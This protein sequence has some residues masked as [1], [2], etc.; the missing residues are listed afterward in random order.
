M[1]KIHRLARIAAFLAKLIV[2]KGVA[3]FIK[4]FKPSLRNVWIISERG[5]DA[6][7]NGYFFYRY[8]VEKHP[9]QKLWYIISSSSPDFAR[10][11]K[12]GKW[13]EYESFRHYVFY[14][15]AK[16]RISSSLWGGDLPKMSYF[17]QL[18][19]FMGHRKK[20]VFLKHGIIKD[21]L[22]QHCYGEGFPD[23]YV[24][25][26][27]P[28]FEYV[29]SNFGYP[30]GIVRYL[31]LARFD[32]LHGKRTKRQVLIMPTFRKWLPS[33][34]REEISGSEYVI[35]WNRAINDPRL[36]DLLEKKEI[37]LIFYP[38]HVMQKN[39]DLFKSVSKRIHIA[40]FKDYDVQTLLIES[41]LL[42]TDFSSVFFDFGYMEKPVIYY[43]FDRERY[44]SEHYDFTKG[45]FS[46]DNNGFGDVVFNDDDLLTSLRKIVENE[47]VLEEKYKERID[48][49]FPLKDTHNC[50]RIYENT[51]DLVAK[52]RI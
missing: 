36:I 45:Y 10:V 16:V 6:R 11:K 19:R 18:R 29:N 25:G 49:F 52:G 43:Q 22:P 51:R 2:A 23:I 3:F 44:I 46:Y 9:E 41:K 20:F 31:G 47:F 15:L 27:K 5:N 13:I 24:C 26:A 14:A 50:D 39:V 7:D 8:M 4:L 34:S 33:M 48:S 21:Y 28:E 1:E 35:T 40:A 30:Q 38:H 12:L 17:K 37:E 32:N 42:I